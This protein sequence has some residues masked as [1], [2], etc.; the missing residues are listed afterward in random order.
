MP[1]SS[2]CSSYSTV[3]FLFDALMFLLQFFV[4]SKFV[5]VIAF[6]LV[7]FVISLGSE[8]I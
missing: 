6:V 1:P 2:H 3:H 4:S 5:L 7:S 8:H